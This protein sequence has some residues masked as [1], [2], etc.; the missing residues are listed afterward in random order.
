MGDSRFAQESMEQELQRYPVIVGKEFRGALA[1]LDNSFTSDELNAWTRQGVDIA[2]V[3]ARSWEVSTEYFRISPAVFNVLSSFPNLMAWGK[4]CHLLAQTSPALA[5]AFVRASPS[6]LDRMHVSWMPIWGEIGQALNTKAWKSNS[7]ACSFFENTPELLQ[8]L[9]FPQLKRLQAFL[10]LVAKSSLDIAQ[11]SLSLAVE[12][13]PSL[14]QNCD[15]FLSLI[16]TMATGNWRQVRNCFSVSLQI[17]PRVEVSQLG[18]LF[19][20]AERLEHSG[21]QAVPLFLQ[22]SAEGLARTDREIHSW[23]LGLGDTLSHAH[24]EAS[25]GFMKTAAN[26][27]ERITP[28]QMEVWFAHGAQLLRENP[29]AGDAFFRVESARSQELLAALSSAVELTSVKEVMRMYCHALAGTEMKIAPTQ[30]LVQKGIGWVSNERPTTE[31]TTIY[32]P[33]VMDKY[34]TKQEN[35]GW[36]KVVATH[37]VAHREFGSFEFTYEKASTLFSDLRP[38]MHP[39]SIDS[40][41]NLITTD[42]HQFFNL[43][44]D[45]KLALDL[46]TITEDGRLDARVQR[47]YPGIRSHYLQVQSD[48]LLERPNVADLPAR[49][50]LVEFL[51]RISLRLQER[52]PIPKAFMRE[53]RSMAR[54]VRRLLV[55]AA[56]VEDAAEATIRIYAILA[57]IPNVE[58]PQDQFEEMDVNDVE[59][60]EEV[61]DE[62][63]LEKMENQPGESIDEGEQP[64][65]SPQEVDYR[66][67]FKPELVQLLNKL[68]ETEQGEK[69]GSDSELQALLEELLAQSA[70]IDLDASDG[71][72]SQQIEKFANNLMRETGATPD[73]PMA[74]TGYRSTV[75]TD[76]EGGPLEVTEPNTQVYDEWDFRA[77]DYKPRWCMVREKWMTEGEV[78]FWYQTLQE[79]AGLV[80]EIRREF[81]ML[82][83][84]NSRKIRPLLDGED[85]DLDSAM[86]FII[87]LRSGGVASDKVYW[88]RNKIE[89]DVAVLF[90]LDVSASTAEAIDEPRRQAD[91]WNAPTDP[92]QYMLWLRTHRGEGSRRT[93]KRIIDLEK[94]SI[95]LLIQALETLGDTYGIYAFS[96]YGR[97]NVEFY[98][99]KDLSEGLSDSVRKRIDRVAP[100][101]ATRMGPAIRHSTAK[102][103]AVHAKTKVLFLI[104][105]GRPQDRGYSRE[106]VEKEYAVNDTHQALVEAHKQGIVPFCLTV[107]KSGHDYL[108]AMCGDMGYEVLTDIQS[109]PKRLPELYR[110]LTI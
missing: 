107:D 10:A 40:H 8:V 66:G 106:G 98:T 47:D 19:S 60:G 104:S 103:A 35:F 59:Q 46:F 49:E 87:D 37:Q 102:L 36:L 89:R 79:D 14:G 29:E 68:R 3:G 23:L 27:L 43:F 39:V 45:R 67:E 81:E 86:E 109:L 82:V 85:Y 61:S 31:G 75:H 99:V 91:E 72:D 12:T 13:F 44:Q 95:V 51:V 70:E 21:Y 93:Y 65:N 69:E 101:H 90:L 53:A 56:T 48:S 16:T 57:T 55:P 4:T 92:I 26:I 2:M 41:E 105:D 6:S 20:M 96:G 25:H 74:T 97:E 83:P 62:E 5:I 73:R 34:Q 15:P 84:E 1:S 100:L 11:E 58:I 52:I 22:E 17:A 63:L 50:A 80:S 33:P 77:G 9:T 78:N 42:M 38:R 94:E 32:L 28:Q 76:D 54:L 7:L 71:Q 110:R 30:A 24:P 18:R 108:K 64:Y 88:W